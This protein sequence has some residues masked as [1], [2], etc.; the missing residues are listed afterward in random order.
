MQDTATQAESLTDEPDTQP[1]PDLR[2][3][4]ERKADRLAILS[5]LGQAL[6]GRSFGHLPRAELPPVWVDQL[7][8][9]GLGYDPKSLTELPEYEAHASYV[10]EAVGALQAMHEALT[11]VIDARNKVKGDPTL[12]QAAMVLTV[13]DFADGKWPAAT[14]RVDAAMKV[15]D[16]RIAEAEASLREGI[17]GHAGGTV[18]TEIRAH[19]KAMRNGTERMAFMR[20][21]IDAGD[22]ES[23]AAVLKAKPFLS[24]LTPAEADMLVHS[25]NAKARPELAPR[26][27][28]LNQVRDHLERVSAPFVLDMQRAVGVKVETVN[29]LR[30]AKAAAKLN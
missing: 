7:A 13:A 20:E 11:V 8:R 5:P 17:P 15:M 24:G 23:V 10:P 1:E 14:R 9:P 21:L 26:I 16:A 22:T 28:F 18:A 27:A 12:T 3:V 29:K 2:T 6:E 4:A 19:V 25:V 30:A